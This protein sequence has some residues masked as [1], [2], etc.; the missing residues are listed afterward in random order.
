MRHQPNIRTWEKEKEHFSLICRSRSVSLLPLHYFSMHSSYSL[1]QL[2]SI[3][4]DFEWSR[5]SLH[6]PEGRR[7]FQDSPFSGWRN[8]SSAQSKMAYYSKTVFEEQG[9]LVIRPWKM[10]CGERSQQT[11][12]WS[13]SPI[14]CSVRLM[15]SKSP[16][17]L[18]QLS[19]FVWRIY[20]TQSSRYSTSVSFTS[21]I[22]LFKFL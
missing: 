8:F 13:T 9:Q 6:Y 2:K 3:D 17:H 22:P 19:A 1:I 16:L 18:W 10:K 11:F 5:V 12:S 20:N 15:Q 14:N 7:K 4:L 21:T